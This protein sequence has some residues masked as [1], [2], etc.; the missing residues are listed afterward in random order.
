M[1]SKC[2]HYYFKVNLD[3]L[4]YIAGVN[5]CFYLVYFKGLRGISETILSFANT[6]VHMILLKK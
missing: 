2:Y 3:P 5:V 6:S 1:F 4:Y